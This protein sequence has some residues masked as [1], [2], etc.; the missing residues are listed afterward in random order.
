MEN[1]NNCNNCNEPCEQRDNCID[2]PRR[3]MAWK[4][5]VYPREWVPE[6]YINTKYQNSDKR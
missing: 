5:T 1:C 2:Q 4:P 6:S 3:Q